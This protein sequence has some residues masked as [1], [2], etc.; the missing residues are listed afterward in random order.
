MAKFYNEKGEE[1]EG[2]TKDELEART[3]ESIEEFAQNN[4]DKSADLQKA[5]DELLAANA[6]FKELEEMGGSEGQKKRLKAEKDEAQNKLAEV[7]KKLTGEM[8]ALKD[9]IFGGRKTKVLDAL[10]KGDV[11]LRKKIELEADSFKGEPANEIELEQR[12]VK[13]ATIVMGNKP[14][15]NFMDGMS[16]GGTRGVDDKRGVTQE[17]DNAK[18]MR[19]VFGITDEQAKKFS[20]DNK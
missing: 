7:E 3:K 4:P 10:T 17:S 6:K 14:Q 1:V 20:P 9:S 11:E 18:E 16:H 12:L 15:P 13:A 8:K 2:Y 19:K 5:Q